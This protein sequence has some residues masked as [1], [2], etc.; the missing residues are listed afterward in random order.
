MGIIQTKL[1][2][3][4]RDSTRQAISV[5][6]MAMTTVLRPMNHSQCHREL[7]LIILM[8]RRGRILILLARFLGCKVSRL[9][10]EILD[11]Y[12]ERDFIALM[13]RRGRFLIWLARFLGCRAWEILD[14]NGGIVTG[15]PKRTM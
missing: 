3:G 15:G 4:A 6:T 9:E 11:A 12:E 13:R 14:V 10:D 2:H 7:V 8:K 1:D 5:M